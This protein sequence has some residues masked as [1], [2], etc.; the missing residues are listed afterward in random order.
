VSDTI[1]VEPVTPARW[2]DLEELF[3]RLGPR[4]GRTYT[5][6]CWC[7]LWR[8][9]AKEHQMGWG[10]DKS[11]ERGKANKALMQTIVERGDRPGLL[12][13]RDGTAVGWCALGPRADLPRIRTSR[14]VADLPE[15]D[16]DGVWSVSCFYV[17]GSHKRRGVAGALLGAAIDVAREA[18]A[19]V[20]EGYPVA[21]G[22]GDPFTGHVALYEAA[23]FAVQMGQTSRGLARLT[24]R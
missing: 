12:A 20:L 15:P 9:S 2:A 5:S 10:A 19:R 7:V 13:Y 14:S 16:D 6:G 3:E 8:V 24:L 23:G 22:H 21:P 17:H 4:G 1:V 11:P 18:G